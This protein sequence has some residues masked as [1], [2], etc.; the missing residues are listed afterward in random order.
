M[1]E[2]GNVAVGLRSFSRKFATGFGGWH[3]ALSSQLVWSSEEDQ[4]L[5][6]ATSKTRQGSSRLRP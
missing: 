3:H 1:T 2:R 5:C 6:L 4:S